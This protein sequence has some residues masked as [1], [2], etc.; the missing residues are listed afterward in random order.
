MNYIKFS[1]F[2]LKNYKNIFLFSKKIKKKRNNKIF[3][4]KNM[5]ILFNKPSTRTRITFEMGFK[6]EGG[7]VVF[8]NSLDTQISRGEN[9]KD[10]TKVL[11]KFCD[12]L[13]VRTYNQKEI[14]KISKY[15]KVPVVNALT[16]SFHPCQVA[17]DL[18]TLLEKT[19]IRNKSILWVGEKNN[20]FKTWLDASKTF[21]FN[22]EAIFPINEKFSII[23]RYK[24][25]KEINKK[26]IAIISDTWDSMKKKKENYKNY[27][28]YKHVK[29]KK[30]N[31]KFT[32]YFLHCLPA[33]NNKEVEKGVIYHK[34]SLVW[35]CVENKKHVQK[36]IIN[37]LI[38]K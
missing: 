2:S 13:V 6:E 12:V 27:N 31:L 29:V 32:K 16:D 4:N 36:G 38:K 26:Y 18:F 5:I 9:I 21:N 10:T 8:L 28:F 35:K 19:K 30:K 23:N 37:F 33:Y 3:Y 25:F 11:S 22:L 24:S 34:K 1:D 15:S 7:N 20:I 17:S 14:E